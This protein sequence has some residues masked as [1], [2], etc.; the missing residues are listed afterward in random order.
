MPD[1][2]QQP[3]DAARIEELEQRG[4][5]DH[6]TITGLQD[7]NVVDQKIIT[8]L[9]DQGELDRVQIAN[10]HEALVT[11]RRIGAAMGIL[12]T[13]YQL[14]QEAA[15][16]ALRISSQHSHRKLREVAEDVLY[17]GATSG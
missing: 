5:L 3:S 12:M 10:L 1:E 7:Q 14:T 2:Q 9:L 13:R 6:D 11:A 17:T 8:A 16:D 15:F 4:Q